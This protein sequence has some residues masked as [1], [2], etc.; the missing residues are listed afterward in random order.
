MVG[1][2]ILKKYILVIILLSLTGFFGI[3]AWASDLSR[4]TLQNVARV[5]WMYNYDPNEIPKDIQESLNSS[6]NSSQAFGERMLMR[7][8]DLIMNPDSWTSDYSPRH[9]MF[10]EY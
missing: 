7:L 9:K 3:S 4:E 8:D 6:A 5:L 10:K 1:Y 2:N